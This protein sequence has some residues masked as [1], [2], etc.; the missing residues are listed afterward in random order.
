MGTSKPDWE[1]ALIVSKVNQYYFTGTMQDG[2]LVIPRNEE[3]VYWVRCSYERALDESTFPN[4][5]H[6]FSFFDA[7]EETKTLPETVYLETEVVP[8]ALYKRLNKHFGFSEARSLDTQLAA[9]RAVKSNYELSIMKKCGKIHRRILEE[10]LPVMLREGMSEAELASELFPLMVREGHQGIARIAMF[11]TEMV[12]GNIC[13]G[14]SSIYPTYFNGP[15]GNYGLSP[16]VPLL[17]SRER[18]LKRGDLVFIDIG[19]G[20]EGYHTDKTMTYMFG[21][22]LPQHVLDDHK[23]CVA[24][25]HQVA[26]MLKPGAVPSEIYDSI[27]ENLE[28]S[29]LKNFMGFGQRSVRF[30]AH[31]IGLTI[32]ELPVIA[33]GFNDPI[34]EHMVFAVEP[35]KGIE[36]IGMVGIEDTFIVTPTGGVSI[37]GTNSGMIPVY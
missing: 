9:V 31:G 13:F 23:Q 17:G 19:C 35:K 15:G 29:F 27:I 2:V 12:M 37:T 14:E 4:I 11:N 3:A 20:L 6:M 5:K 32:D 34:E 18:K 33:Q 36:E 22:P 30:L 24:I 26:G 7:A 8:L 10:L 21:R 1:M 16:S 25:Q 28:P